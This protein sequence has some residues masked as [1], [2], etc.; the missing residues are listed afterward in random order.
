MIPA[1]SSAA[2]AIQVQLGCRLW[3]A[4]LGPPDGLVAMGARRAS[5]WIRSCGRSAQPGIWVNLAL[6]TAFAMPLLWS[7]RRLRRQNGLEECRMRMVTIV[8]LILGL[9]LLGAAEGKGQK[10][11]PGA[12][13]PQP[14]DRYS[15]NGE[16]PRPE[17]TSA[18]WG[19]QSADAATG[20]APVFAG[21][22]L[23]RGRADRDYKPFHQW[24]I[25]LE[26]GT[27]AVADLE[28][29]MIVLGPDMQPLLGAMGTGHWVDLGRLEPGEQ[30]DCSYK[31][32][33]SAPTAIRGELRWQGG[34]ASYLT[35]D[36][37][38]LPVLEGDTASAAKLLVMQPDFEANPKKKSAKISFFLRNDG[39]MPATGVVHTVVF[40]DH[41]GKEV[42]RVEHVPTKDG[43]VPPGFAEQI[44]FEVAKVPKFHDIAVSTKSAE[45]TAGGLTLDGG[46][47]T[48]RADI[49]VAQVTIEDG[50]LSAAV[51][52]GLPDPVQ[53]LI[54]TLD[55][56]DAAGASLR[57]VDLPVGALAP[58]ERKRL[59]AH[60]G[61]IPP[62]LGWGVGFSFGT[63]APA[64]ADPARAAGGVLPAMDVDGIELVI[65]DVEA[66][67]SAVK[68]DLTVTNKRDGD[69][70]QLRCKLQV[71]SAAGTSITIP[72]EIGDLAQGAVFEGSVIGE[73]VGDVA[74]VQM[75][76]ATGD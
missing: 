37:Q 65:T 15:K 44:R 8:F 57:Q 22:Y 34:Q 7:P 29:R 62:V 28:L 32:N 18:A 50:R 56:L 47:F 16:M 41:T 27:E 46:E 33:C 4:V 10:D 39:G 35:V 72:L 63:A 43:S 5:R 38:G 67:G 64:T 23:W 49:E 6:G 51:R 42:H 31:L 68:L 54:V 19:R 9:G 3:V 59:E 73:G 66:A 58:E 1:A 17:E 75:A 69:L 14:H 60:L 71:K 25:L 45:Q 76:W 52:N 11:G 53:D 36:P 61:A 48:G 12:A 13:K 74:A 20:A 30:V 21:S 70:S 24:E 26:G 40:R 55:L 2:E